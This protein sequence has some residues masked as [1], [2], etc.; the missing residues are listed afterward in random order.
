MSGPFDRPG[1]PRLLFICGPLYP[2]P[3]IHSVESCISIPD[4]RGAWK[5]RR[6]GGIHIRTYQMQFLVL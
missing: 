1:L 3:L 6:G 4:T 5:E 2:L